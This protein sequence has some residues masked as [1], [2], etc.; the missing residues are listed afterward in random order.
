MIIG[1]ENCYGVYINLKKW[2][3]QEMEKVKKDSLVWDRV[4]I[5]ESHRMGP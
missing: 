2:G 3:E 1:I 5:H 4:S